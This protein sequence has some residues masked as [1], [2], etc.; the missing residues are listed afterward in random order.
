MTN[1][2]QNAK[3]T[4]GPW[5]VIDRA[6]NGGEGVSIEAENGYTEVCKV[7]KSYHSRTANAR[8]IA[9]APELLEALKEAENWLAEYEDG[10]D[11][12]LQGLLAQARAAIAKA[13]G[14]G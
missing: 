5:K 1:A 10:P 2:S 7:N 14:R 3:H 6:L 9:A 11:S 12:G 8:L 4:P 13:E